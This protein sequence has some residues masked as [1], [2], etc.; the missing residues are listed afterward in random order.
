MAPMSSKPCARDRGVQV[1]RQEPTAPRFPLCHWV[2]NI[3]FLLPTRSQL[4]SHGFLRFFP[5]RM[6]M[7]LQEPTG[8]NALLRG[9]LLLS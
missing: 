1:L 3:L 7:L 2:F 5:I 9:L 6:E 8:S 4:P